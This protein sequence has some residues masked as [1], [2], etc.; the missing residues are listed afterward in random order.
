M[1]MHFDDDN[2][3]LYTDGGNPIDNQ[4]FAT[5]F[6]MG[7]YFAAHGLDI[8]EASISIGGQD[9]GNLD[10]FLN[11]MHAMRPNVE[12]DIEDAIDEEDCDDVYL[13]PEY[14]IEILGRDDDTEED[15]EDDEDD[16]GPEELLEI[17]KMQLLKHKQPYIVS[18]ITG[19]VDM[20]MLNGGMAKHVT[21]GAS[22]S[23]DD[24]ICLLVSAITSCA[25]N[26]NVPVHV[27]MGT[28]L[29]HLIHNS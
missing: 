14:G 16:L 7:Q 24:A 28:L 12:D 11:A 18:Y 9:M 15:D 5:G 26:Y 25:R 10:E 13:G 3:N 21:V 23:Y 17:M 27:I 29:P 6:R 19:T 2:N 1:S 8:S 20:R 4:A 22:G